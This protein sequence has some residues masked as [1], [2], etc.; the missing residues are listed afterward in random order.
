MCNY[1][2]PKGLIYGYYFGDDDYYTK[3]RLVWGRKTSTKLS[4]K[5]E[6]EFDSSNTYYT[7]PE[8]ITLYRYKYADVIDRKTL[9][10]FN[11]SKKEI[12]GNCEV[13]HYRDQLVDRMNIYLKK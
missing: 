12:I 8:Y 5:I 7:S 11:Q 4:S 1:I 13:M 10:V 9:E 2:L 3:I 6:L